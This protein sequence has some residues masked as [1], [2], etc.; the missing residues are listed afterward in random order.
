MLQKYH[1]SMTFEWDVDLET[2]FL[3]WLDNIMSEVEYW[4]KEVANAQGRRHEYNISCRNKTVFTHKS[5]SKMIKTDEIVLDIGCGL[6][7]KFGNRLEDGSKVQLV[8]VD[9]LAHFYNQINGR[10]HDGLR[11]GYQ[12]RFGMFEFLGNIFG[13]GFADYIVIDNALDHCIDP[14]RSLVECLYVLKREG[15]MFLN[16]RRAEARLFMRIGRACIDGI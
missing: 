11:E 10:I 2:Y 13:Q 8:P 4:V 14:W 6:M 1:D 16:H 7:S 3:D 12:C 15:H 9:A 5:I